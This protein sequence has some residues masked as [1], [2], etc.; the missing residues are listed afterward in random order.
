MVIILARPSIRLVSRGIDYIFYRKT[1]DYRQEL[2]DFNKKMSHILNLDELAKE[3]L[4]TIS[5]AIDTSSAGL[6]LQTVARKFRNAVCLSG[7]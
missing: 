2:L 7:E 5:K 4:P 6:I 3:I 1:Y